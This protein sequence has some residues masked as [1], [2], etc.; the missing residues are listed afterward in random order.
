MFFNSSSSFVI[1]S[2]KSNNLD[3]IWFFCFLLISVSI[4]WTNFWI[5]FLLF[6]SKYKIKFSLK[7]YFNNDEIGCLSSFILS[8]GNDL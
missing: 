6:S 1:W 2:T 3:W 5:S 8:S 4:S 7:S